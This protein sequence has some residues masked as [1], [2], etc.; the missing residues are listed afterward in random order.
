MEDLTITVY[1]ADRPYRLKIRAE[2]EEFVQ[3]AVKDI[4]ERIREYSETYAYNDRQDLLA[5]A[6]LSI[7]GGVRP[8]AR[9][10]LDDPGLETRLHRLHGLIDGTVV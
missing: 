6:A 10:G 3:Q 7:A 9:K 5:M 4:N 8:M 1:I 2:E